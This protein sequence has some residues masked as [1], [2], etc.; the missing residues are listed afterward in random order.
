ESD[1]EGDSRNAI[2]GARRVTTAETLAAATPVVDADLAGK[3]GID[4]SIHTLTIGACGVHPGFDDALP[5]YAIVAFGLDFGRGHSR[6][7]SGRARCGIR[8]HIRNFLLGAIDVDCGFDFEPLSGQL[9]MTVDILHPSLGS[10]ISRAV[11]RCLWRR[12]RS[13]AGDAHFND[14]GAS[15]GK[16]L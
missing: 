6:R 3:S 9:R 16:I 4:D 14:G 7:R 13:T 11:V 10:Q 1:R 12:V 15:I 2:G 5:K 8:A